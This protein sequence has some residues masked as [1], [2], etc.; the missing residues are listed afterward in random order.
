MN[1]FFC[2][3]SLKMTCIF[4]FRRD[5][6]LADNPALIYALKTFEQVLPIFIYDHFQLTQSDTVR[7][8][9]S[10]R[11]IAAQ[12]EGLDDLD[13]YLNA[14]GSHL[15]RYYGTPH[16]IVSWLIKK[17]SPVA[18][19]FN[20]DYSEYSQIRDA[21]IK[22]VCD[23]AKIKCIQ[24]HDL[25]THDGAP[26]DKR[27]HAF[28]QGVKPLGVS[29]N[30][31]TNYVKNCSRVRE[32]PPFLKI[33]GEREFTRK[34]AIARLRQPFSKNSYEEN[35]H[36]ISVH[37]KLGLISQREVYRYGVTEKK[38]ELV[39]GM[40]WREFFFA[41]WRAHP[42][43]YTFYDP[44]FSGIVWKNDPSEIKALWGAR[45][46]YPLIDAAV[47]ELNRTGYM[48]N[49]GRLIVGFFAVK[50]LR[51]NPWLPLVGGQAYFSRKLTDC[52]YANNTGNWHWVSSDL[53]DA[54][55][56]RFGKGWAGR[57]ANPELLRPGDAEYIERWGRKKKIEP[58]V[59]WRERWREWCEYTRE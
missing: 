47:R 43:N 35:H 55:G 44:R 59:S 39:K 28:I 25:L 40:L 3:C 19:A 17:K 58:I 57:P 31:R 56:Q 14:H 41:A 13:S 12:E 6:R 54:S 34:I 37:I 48:I 53:L 7:L 16:K 45:T 27:F 10:H 23:E 20:A 50:I 11:F 36:H 2:P 32:A 42:Q 46:G 29:K 22:R 52:C 9:K 49:R 4:I 51:I 18:V 21:E 26:F 38:L 1:I 15:C 8:E 24:A 30:G 33:T 5:L